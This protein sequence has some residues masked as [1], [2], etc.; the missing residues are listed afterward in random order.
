MTK[1]AKKQIN[2]LH[3]NVI[4]SNTDLTCSI[5]FRI[6]RCALSRL[7]S[8]S[9]RTDNNIWELVFSV[10]SVLCFECT[11][12]RC[13][14]PIPLSL[15]AMSA[16]PNIIADITPN[17]FASPPQFVQDDTTIPFLLTMAD[18]PIPEHFDKSFDILSSFC[19]LSFKY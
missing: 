5:F 18:A 16:A 10:I 4:F 3:F 13:A 14:V 15:D 9:V 12:T 19:F 17:V 1:Q 8:F 2:C 6:L 11:I 7:R